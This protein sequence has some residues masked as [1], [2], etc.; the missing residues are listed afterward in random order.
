MITAD[1]L[2]GAINYDPETG[3]LTW[4][5]RGPHSKCEGTRVGSTHSCG[6]IEASILKK[7]MFAHQAAWLYMTG[8]WPTHQID[9]INGVRKDNRW[10]NL[11]AATQQNNSANMRRRSN[12]KSGFKGVAKNK[13]GKF[14]AYIHV[15]GKT[16]YLGSYS[17]AA[18]AHE[19]YASAAHAHWGSFARTE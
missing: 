15:N 7:R 9:H 11:R 2:R 19:S 16:N 17:T 18:D 12:N 6:Y 3:I 1:Q 4:K 10:E 5:K 14:I 13:R 8:E